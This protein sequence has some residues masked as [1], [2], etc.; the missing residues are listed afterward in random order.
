VVVVVDYSGF[1]VA[2]VSYRYGVK[3]GHIPVN[4]RLIY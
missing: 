3:P 4:R 1:G 2:G